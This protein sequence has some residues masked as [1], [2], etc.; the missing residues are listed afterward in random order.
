VS[1]FFLPSAARSG[2]A[3][4]SVVLQ[5]TWSVTLPDAG[6][7]VAASSPT[8][9]T[10]D[11]DGPSIVVGD[12]AGHV[13]AY[14]LRDGS[15]VAGWPASTSGVPVDSTPS[16]S[17]STVFVGVGNPT[18]P[19]AGG[20]EAVAGNGRPVWFR[21]IPMFP[22]PAAG[23]DAGV[24]SSLAVGDLQGGTDV[25]GGSM[26]QL[27]DAL[28]A[29]TGAVLAGFPWFQADSNFSSPALADLFGNGETEIIEGGDSTAGLAFGYQYQNGG[30]VRVLSGT[31]SLLCQY[32]TDQV[33]QSSPAVGQFLGGGAVGIAVGTGHFYPGAS[34]TNQVLALTPGCNLAWA[35]T[36]DGWTD[37][38]P[39]LARVVGNGQLQ[40]AEGTNIGGNYTSGSVWLLDGVTG[41]P[42]WHV[43]ALGAVVGGIV[44]ADLGGGYQDLV[45]TTTA[46][47]EILDGRTGGVVA[48]ADRLSLAMQNSALVTE[49]PNGTVGVTVAGYDNR[50]EGVITHFEVPGSQGSRASEAGAWPMFHHDSQ[51]TGDAG[52]P[53]PAPCRRPSSAARGYYLAAADGGMFTFGNLPF[54]GSTGNLVL[55]RLVVDLAATP[56]AGGYWLVAA[57]GGIFAFGDARFHGSTG[58]VRLNQP[59]VGMAPTADG[60]GYWLVAADGGIFAFGDARFHGSTGVIR[61]NRPVVGMAASR[62][63]GG[64]WLVA[65]DGGIFAF[66]APFYG[67]TGAVHL[68]QPIVA[69]AGF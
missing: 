12:R 34:N 3:A 20:Y 19:N 24:D 45:V 55:N 46:G 40:V 42:I 58:A 64:Y 32:N 13:Y 47:L 11:G 5:A 36:L 61:L 18:N 37:S 69:A 35:R 27:Q 67:S 31:G 4:A 57:D 22:P 44:T 25:V 10:L 65:S 7:P 8:L 66:D 52:T 41:Q 28:N 50:N 14:H 38:S 30:H 60:N 68:S 26:G 15:P 1:A 17:G 51:L 56:D 9:V 43:P 63:T 6:G 62:S 59:V 16:S 49:D 23:P 21:S 48:T 33:V 54:C 29:S 2:G 39:A 53:P